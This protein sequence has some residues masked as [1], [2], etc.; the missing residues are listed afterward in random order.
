VPR[1][2]SS[3]FHV[4]NKSSLRQGKQLTKIVV[5]HLMIALRDKILVRRG[6]AENEVQKLEKK[7]TGAQRQIRTLRQRY[8][9]G[10][11]GDDKED[12]AQETI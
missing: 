10:W 2:E 9:R 6:A 11:Q 7:L 4:G 8:E 12:C 5:R 1:D 3:S